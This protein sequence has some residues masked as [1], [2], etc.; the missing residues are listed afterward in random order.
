[1]LFLRSIPTHLSSPLLNVSLVLDFVN[2]C[3]C[4]KSGRLKSELVRN[5]DTRKFC[6]WDTSHRI[7]PLD[8]TICIINIFFLHF[9][10]VQAR[11]HMSENGTFGNWTRP[12]CPKSGRAWISINCISKSGSASIIP[13]YLSSSH[14][15][16]Q[17]LQAVFAIEC[18]P[19]LPSYLTVICGWTLI[20]PS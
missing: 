8:Q 4:L 3:R 16:G 9:K 6:F 2:Y 12:R 17:D 11:S 7:L 10:M 14:R 5:A 20:L 15:F 13:D 1:M 18:Q 19:L